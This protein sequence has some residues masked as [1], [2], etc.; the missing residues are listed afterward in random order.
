MKYLSESFLFCISQKW[1]FYGPKVLFQCFPNISLKVN[2]CFA[3]VFFVRIELPMSYIY[4]MYIN[5]LL[6][7]FVSFGNIYIHLNSVWCLKIE[8]GQFCW[9]KTC[10]LN[11]Y[12]YY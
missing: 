12:F 10:E 6:G 4:V 9:V 11:G 7:M 5:H 2:L 3:C 8:M 1:D